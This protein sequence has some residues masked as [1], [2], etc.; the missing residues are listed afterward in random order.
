M[1]M[2]EWFLRFGRI[3]SGG[4]MKWIFPGDDLRRL[5]IELLHVS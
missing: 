2:L 5:E 3:N 1:S 4:F